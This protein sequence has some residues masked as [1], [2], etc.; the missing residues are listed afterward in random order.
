MPRSTGFSGSLWVELLGAYLHDSERLATGTSFVWAEQYDLYIDNRHCRH[1]CPCR[2]ITAA[3]TRMSV[4][5]A[6][7]YARQ[8]LLIDRIRSVQDIDTTISYDRD[9][10]AF[11]T[12]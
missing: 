12:H 2:P 9:S 5:F 1:R 11:E 8:L 4:L 3:G 6:T 7:P 10:D